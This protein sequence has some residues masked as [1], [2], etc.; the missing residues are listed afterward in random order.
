MIFTSLDL[1]AVELHADFVALPCLALASIATIYV[2]IG[3]A[4]GNRHSQSTP[5]EHIFW[6]A[7]VNPLI[8]IVL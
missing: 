7:F 5:K 8:A 3:L 1:S 6:W 4:F 2:S